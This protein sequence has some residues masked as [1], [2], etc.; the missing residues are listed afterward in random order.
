MNQHP[1]S[2]H[3]LPIVGVMGSGRTQ[4]ESQATPLGRWLATIDVHLLTGGGCGVMLSVS[5]AFAETEARK[6]SVIGVIPG[7]FDEGSKTYAASA[8]Y[9]NRY[10][11]I[12][13]YTHLPYSGDQGK[14]QLSR[15]HINVLSSDVIVVLPGRSGTAAEA[16]LAVIYNKPVVAWLDNQS[17][18]TNL[19][20]QVPLVGDLEQVKEFVTRQVRKFNG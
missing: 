20:P 13:I 4:F 16:E 14:D 2:T 12:P 19:H 7:Q 17:Q 10:V 8:G 15:N 18:I 6:G 9:P 1:Q 11:E 3:S 5:R